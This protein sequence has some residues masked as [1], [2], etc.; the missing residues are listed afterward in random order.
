M[1]IA[2]SA[3]VAG[4][5]TRSPARSWAGS[6]TCARPGSR[7]ATLDP[8]PT[9]SRRRQ[10][11]APTGGACSVAGCSAAPTRLRAAVPVAVP[12]RA[13]RPV[14][15]RS[16]AGR[17]GSAARPGG[18]P[19]SGRTPAGPGCAARNR[20]SVLG[21]SPAATRRPGGTSR[22]VTSPAVTSPAVGRSVGMSRAVTSRAMMSRAGMSRAATSRVGTGREPATCPASR[23]RRAV[24]GWVAGSRPCVGCAAPTGA[25]IGAR[26]YPRRRYRRCRP[27]Y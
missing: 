23:V 20:A 15:P 1:R 4:A 16:P 2:A 14:R 22:A 18:V 8:V 24:G 19:I 21:T 9:R 25:R 10:R 17:G 6:R 5:V 3:R 27:R 11:P 13:H 7:A 12:A 26:R